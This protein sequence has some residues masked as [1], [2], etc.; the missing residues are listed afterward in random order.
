[1]YH[2]LS[3][4]LTK[5]WNVWM[6]Q[7][8]D[9]MIKWTSRIPK[10]GSHSKLHSRTSTREYQNYHVV[11]KSFFWYVRIH[12]LDTAIHTSMSV[13]LVLKN[14]SQISG[15]GSW[16]TS[17]PGLIWDGA[18]SSFGSLAGGVGYLMIP[19]EKMSWGPFISSSH[20][21]KETVHVLGWAWSCSFRI[22]Q[23]WLVHLKS[24]LPFSSPMM[25]NDV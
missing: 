24:L 16:L 10:C 8:N 25:Y 18:I 3:Q 7:T 9:L 22:H 19:G 20:G 5:C 11:D 12:F 2:V 1:M 6:H 23:L 14:R 17:Q 21:Y 13:S 4:F 15:R